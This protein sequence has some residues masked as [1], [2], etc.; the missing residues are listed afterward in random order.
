MNYDNI[1][2]YKLAICTYC[3]IFYQRV[4][5]HGWDCSTSLLIPYISNLPYRLPRHAA[6]K[7][8]LYLPCCTG[9][10]NMC[11]D[12]HKG[13]NEDINGLV[14]LLKVK[15]NNLINLSINLIFVGYTSISTVYGL[16]LSHPGRNLDVSLH[17][18]GPRASQSCH[19]T[20]LSSRRKRGKQ[21][22]DH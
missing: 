17:I 10:R 2:E 6:T 18:N 5:D 16:I 7:S 4:L 19:V 20:W 15:Q 1:K 12:G 13:I 3:F 9:I 22:A 21:K 11:F 8:K 14:T